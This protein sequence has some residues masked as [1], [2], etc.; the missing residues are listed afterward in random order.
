MTDHPW[1]QTCRIIW[2]TYRG[3]SSRLLASSPTVPV[4]LYMDSACELR[5]GR[6]T[7]R[8]SHIYAIGGTTSRTSTSRRDARRA[9]AGARALPLRQAT[10]L[11]WRYTVGTVWWSSASMYISCEKCFLII[12]E[13]TTNMADRTPY[14]PHPSYPAFQI[15]ACIYRVRLTQ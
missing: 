11:A 7:N 6:G 5:T 1:M 3:M 10:T 12:K 15:T 9:V 8:P 13:T 4:L 14:N 2:M